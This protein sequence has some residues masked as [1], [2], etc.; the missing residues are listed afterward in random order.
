MVGVGSVVILCVCPGFIPK[1]Q[2]SRCS[3]QNDLI[4][5][6]SWIV[7]A[8]SGHIQISSLTEAGLGVD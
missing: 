4:Q 3:L 2:N 1:I 7:E 6:D 5:V 8:P